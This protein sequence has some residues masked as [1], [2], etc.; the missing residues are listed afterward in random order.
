MELLD[1]ATA[2]LQRDGEEN[3]LTCLRI[4]FDLHKNFRPTSCAGKSK[5]TPSNHPL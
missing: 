2:T 3:A 5:S 4:V 1:L